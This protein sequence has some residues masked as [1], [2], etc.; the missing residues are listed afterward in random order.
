M[1]NPKV[2]F[3]CTG[4]SAHNQVMEG[5][6]LLRASAG[7]FSAG[8]KLKDRLVSAV[9]D[10]MH[11]VKIYISSRLLKSVMEY[12]NKGNL[13]Y[14]ITVDVGAEENYPVAFLTTKIHT[15]WSFEYPAEIDREERFSSVRYVIEE[16]LRLWLAEG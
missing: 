13:V 12:R 5:Q 15:P 14:V 4:N 9:F 3:P 2:L 10:M 1:P 7:V 16:R 8:T 11:E 6:G